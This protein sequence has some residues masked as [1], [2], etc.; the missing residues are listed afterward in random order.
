MDLELLGVRQFDHF[1]EMRYRF[2]S[3]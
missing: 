1:A 3:K 2:K